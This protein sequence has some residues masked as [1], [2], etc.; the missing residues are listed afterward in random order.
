MSIRNLQNMWDAII[1]FGYKVRKS[2]EDGLESWNKIKKCLITVSTSGQW[3]PEIKNVYTYMKNDLGI[4]EEL[5]ECDN[6]VTWEKNHFY[7]QHARILTL[8]FD[9]PKVYRLM[10][11]AYNV[12]Q[13]R[14]IFDD[15]FYTVEMKKYYNENELDDMT[16]YMSLESLESINN[17]IDSIKIM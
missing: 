17:S 4:K 14:A 7:L 8:N 9:E 11:I 15:D 3:N 10:Q 2:G 1:D 5:S 16:T 12:G 6:K 13:L